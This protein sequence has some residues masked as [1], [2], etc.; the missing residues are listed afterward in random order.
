MNFL[1]PRD[2]AIHFAECSAQRKKLI[3]NMRTSVAVMVGG[4]I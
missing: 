1:Q 4:Q 3:E 2:P